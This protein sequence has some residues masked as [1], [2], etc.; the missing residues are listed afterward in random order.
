MKNERIKSFLTTIFSNSPATS[1]DIKTLAES[2][3]VL[4]SE[5]TKMTQLFLKMSKAVNEHTIALEQIVA[6]QEYMLASLGD[7]ILDTN[8][9]NVK[10][11]KIKSEKP[12]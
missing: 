12:N 10:S 6:V 9:T 11:N 5:V 1:E 3:T 7:E 8:F 4:A 2:V